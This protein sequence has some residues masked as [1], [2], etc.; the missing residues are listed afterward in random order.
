MRVAKKIII[1]QIFF[2]IA[3]SLIANKAFFSHIHILPDGKIIVHAHP[4]SKN[5][6]DNKSKQ[7]NHTHTKIDFYVIDQSNKFD[8]VPVDFRDFNFKPDFPILSEIIVGHHLTSVPSF[9]E[10]ISDRGPPSLFS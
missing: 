6:Q 4:Y 1:S 2:L 7:A 5:N 9:I 3:V 10:F 8:D